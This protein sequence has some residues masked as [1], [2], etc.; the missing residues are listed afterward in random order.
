MCSIFSSARNAWLKTWLCGLNFTSTDLFSMRKFKT[1][2]AWRALP[3]LVRGANC[4]NLL[5]LN[6]AVILLLLSSQHRQTQLISS[7][8][9]PFL[10]PFALALPAK[11]KLSK[12][13]NDMSKRLRVWLMMKCSLASTWTASLL[14]T[15][16][17]AIR[18]KIEKES[19]FL[20]SLIKWTERRSLFRIKF[21]L[22]RS[23][24]SL[25]STSLTFWSLKAMI[26]PRDRR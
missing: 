14:L 21:S 22:L 26:I 17:Q 15:Q 9:T 10:T 8:T 11:L 5:W 4:Q 2:S 13:F 6:F 23:I 3:L 25:K 20:R 24:N 16:N 7:S 19:L 1:I 12:D 18:M